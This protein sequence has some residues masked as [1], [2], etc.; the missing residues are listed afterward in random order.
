MEPD[1][2]HW[3]YVGAH[4]RQMHA[5]DLETGNEMWRT[6]TFNWILSRAAVEDYTVYF[7][8]MDGHVYALDAQCGAV[9]W[10]YRVGRHLRYAEQVV[11]GSVVCEAVCGSPLVSGGVVYCGADDGFLY[12][13]DAATGEE[14]WHLR[15]NKWI[16]GRPL[17]IQGVLV[18]ASADGQV[19]GLEPATGRELWRCATGNANYADVVARRDAVLIASTDGRLYELEA[20]DGS[21]RWSFDADAGLRAAPA[22]DAENGSIYLGTCGGQLLSIARD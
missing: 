16:W 6:P 8:S 17:L 14:R 3:L 2:P 10:R 12:A 4:D 9:K 1:A 7:G 15:T 11:P 13:L 21:V 18:V 5:F 19:Y 22:V 20:R